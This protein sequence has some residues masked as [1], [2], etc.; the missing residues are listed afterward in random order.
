VLLDE[1]LVTVFGQDAPEGWHES[2]NP[3]SYELLEAK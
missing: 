3:K 1:Q 2:C